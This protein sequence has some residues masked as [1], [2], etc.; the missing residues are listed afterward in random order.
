MDYID[1]LD[2]GGNKYQL[3]GGTAWLL[4]CKWRAGISN[5]YPSISLIWFGSP[6][7]ITTSTITDDQLYELLAKRGC[8][9]NDLDRDDDDYYTPGGERPAIFYPASGLYC[10]F[11]GGRYGNIIGIYAEAIYNNDQEPQSK[12]VRM[13]IMDNNNERREILT[14]TLSV[15]KLT[16]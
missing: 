5:F 13:I 16:T 11:S 1:K 10:D 8:F 6:N 3:G 12:Y 4:T 9:I 2:I 15:T 7:D 14:H